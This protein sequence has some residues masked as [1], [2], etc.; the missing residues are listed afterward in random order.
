MAIVRTLGCHLKDLRVGKSRPGLC[1]TFSPNFT[2]TKDQGTVKKPAKLLGVTVRR[3]S[4][5]SR[6]ISHTLNI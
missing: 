5:S 2:T 1:I 3:T 4:I 6:G